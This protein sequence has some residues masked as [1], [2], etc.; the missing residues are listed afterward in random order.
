MAATVDGRIALRDGRP[1]KLSSEEDFARVHRL[2]AEC[3]AV[4]V[5]IETVLA[6][7]PKLTVKT[8]YAPGARHPLRV[9]LDSTGRLPEDRAVLDGRAPTL[10]V[11][12]EGT[13]RTYSGADV[14][15]CGTGRVDLRRLLENLAERG[16]ARVLVE[17][18]GRVAW[19]FLSEGLVDRFHLYLAPAI[20]GDAEAPALLAG[21]ASDERDDLLPLRLREVTRLGGGLLLTFAPGQR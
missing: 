18:G 11:T 12:A 1:L 8:A 16:L 19:S 3:D 5:G 20:M 14:L 6:D 13:D 9:V 15:R 7:D 2:R 17:G 4:V 10:V 21:N